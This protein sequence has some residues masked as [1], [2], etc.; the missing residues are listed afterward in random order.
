M[1]IFVVVRLSNVTEPLGYGQ[2]CYNL[3][4]RRESFKYI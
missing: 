1:E 4:F 2:N 3:F